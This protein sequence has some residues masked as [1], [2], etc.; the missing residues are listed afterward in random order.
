M[1]Q[2][3]VPFLY[4]DL[5]KRN[6]I[7]WA[8]IKIREAW[9]RSLGHL[10][11]IYLRPNLRKTCDGHSLR[12]WWARCIDINRKEKAVHRQN[13]WL[14][15]IPIW[16][17]IQCYLMAALWQKLQHFHLPVQVNPSPAYP[18]LQAH[19]KAPTVLVQ[20]A[21]SLQPPLF[22]SHSSISTSQRIK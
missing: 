16:W 19:V 2:G 22:V 8:V 10:F 3:P 6:D 4:C 1:S 9:A 20:L 13:L 12:G 14:S 5:Y 21:S 11:E 17:L 7:V 18:E 15:D